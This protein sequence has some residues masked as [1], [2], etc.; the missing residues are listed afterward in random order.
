MKKVLFFLVMFVAF[1]AC[2]SKDEP[3]ADPRDAFVGD[4]S[5]VSEGSI[6]LYAGVSKVFTIPMNETGDLSIKPATE[7]NAVWVIAE[8][9]STKGY[10]SGSQLFMDPTSEDTQFGELNLHLSFTY[11]KATLQDNQLSWPSDVAIT[12]SYKDYNLLGNG[13]VDITATKKK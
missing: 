8:S 7:S 6:D 4:Y 13:R 9:D 11:G 12:A 3:S 2:R 10:V 1:A 5:F